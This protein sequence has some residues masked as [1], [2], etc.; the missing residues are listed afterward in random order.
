MPNQTTD[1][2]TKT[3]LDK[4]EASLKQVIEV[5]KTQKT[6]ADID[7]MLKTLSTTVHHLKTKVEFDHEKR[8]AAIEEFLQNL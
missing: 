6:Q 4:I 8:L 7:D 5:A 3:D 1:R 2:I